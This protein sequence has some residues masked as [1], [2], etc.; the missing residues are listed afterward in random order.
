MKKGSTANASG[1][2]PRVFGAILGRDSRPELDDSDRDMSITWSGVIEEAGHCACV[3]RTRID[4]GVLEHV[5]P[6]TGP[7]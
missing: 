2:I 3:C 7:R 5:V 6:S 1:V 4:S